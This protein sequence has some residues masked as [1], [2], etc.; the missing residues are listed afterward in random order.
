MD[1]FAKTTMNCDN[2]DPSSCCLMSSE[3]FIAESVQ[4]KSG[5]NVGKRSIWFN[6][7]KMDGTTNKRTEYPKPRYDQYRAT[8]FSIFR[9][10]TELV[11]APSA[12]EERPDQELGS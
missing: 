1:A 5:K 3:Q 11:V 8:D 7:T 9:E 10:V 12:D 4:N 2:P 6:G